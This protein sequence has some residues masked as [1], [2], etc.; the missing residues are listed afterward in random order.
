MDLE[1]IKLKKGQEIEYISCDVGDNGGAVLHYTIKKTAA[2]YDKEERDSRTEIFSEE[3]FETKALPRILE[4]YKAN[5][6]AKKN[7]VGKKDSDKVMSRG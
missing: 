7:G 4:L 6:E 2:T 5:Y 1:P 3:E